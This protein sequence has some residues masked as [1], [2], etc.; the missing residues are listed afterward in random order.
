M[1]GK[2]VERGID[3]GVDE[4]AEGAAALVGGVE[5]GAVD[6]DPEALVIPDVDEGI[7]EA[8]LLAVVP[9]ELVVVDLDHAAVVELFHGVIA[10]LGGVPGCGVV[11]V[12][13]LELPEEVDEAVDVFGGDGLLHD[14]EAVGLPVLEI[15][16]GEH[17]E[18]QLLGELMQRL[19]YGCGC[20][21]VISGLAL[22]WLIE[23]RRFSHC[24]LLGAASAMKKQ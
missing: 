2:R 6:G 10:E 7:V 14:D 8:L 20:E 15:V 22:F 9:E 18:G 5:V 24:C 16:G 1:T 23:N 4:A 19:A 3:V 21:F 17:A 13:L 11:G 12:H